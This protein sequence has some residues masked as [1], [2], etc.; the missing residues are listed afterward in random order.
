MGALSERM[1]R[2]YFRSRDCPRAQRYTPPFCCRKKNGDVVLGR[3][4]DLI[5]THVVP[6]ASE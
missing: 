5:R 1:T 2:R 6:P 4:I 3:R